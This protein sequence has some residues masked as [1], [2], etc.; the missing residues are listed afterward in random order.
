MATKKILEYIVT[1]EDGIFAFTKKYKAVAHMRKN[2]SSIGQRLQMKIRSGKWRK[3]EAV[4][5]KRTTNFYS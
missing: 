1:C 4:T 3:L 2:P 5:W